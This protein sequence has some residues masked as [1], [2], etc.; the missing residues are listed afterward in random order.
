MRRV[1][2]G[3]V[4]VRFLIVVSALLVSAL[5][6]HAQNWV[7]QGP[8]GIQGTG[9]QTMNRV[10]ATDQGLLAVGYDGP[11]SN[12]DAAVWTSVNGNQWS[13]GTVPAGPFKEGIAAVAPG[14]PGFVAVGGSDTTSGS[15]A[16]V[17]GIA[18]TTVDRTHIRDCNLPQSAAGEEFR[19]IRSGCFLA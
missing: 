17:S 7:E 13:Q 11:A 8:N 4:A 3:G 9:N 10:S 19:R 14:G 16:I 12:L 1:V 5:P 18:G 15:D 6:A 2:S